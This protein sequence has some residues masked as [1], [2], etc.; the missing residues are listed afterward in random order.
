MGRITKGSFFCLGL[1][2]TSPLLALLIG[3][4]VLSLMSI[5]LVLVFFNLLFSHKE[6]YEQRRGLSQY[7]LGWMIISLLSTIFGFI[8]FYNIDSRYSFAA[9][10]FLPKIVLYLFLYF[11]LETDK[12]G[13]SKSSY[14][15]NG[16]KIGI[17]LNLVWSIVD[18]IMYYTL[19]IS[20]TNTVFASYIQA[21]DMHYGIASIVDGITIRSVGLNNDPATIGFFSIAGAV[22]GSVS[23]KKWMI[24]VCFLAALS[25]VSF[26]GVLGILIA[27]AANFSIS[28]KYQYKERIKSHKYANII[29]I[30]TI[31]VI[32]SAWVINTENGLV[33]QF[34]T[35]IELRAESKIEG[36]HSGM[37]RELFLTKFPHCVAEL[38]TSLF[39]GTGYY[40]GVYAY[41]QEG[42][43]YGYDRPT[44]MEN[45]YVDNFFSFGLIG[46]F[47]FVAFYIKMSLKSFRLLCLH[48]I[49]QFKTIYS[50]G[51]AAL[52]SFFTYH[53]TLYSVIMLVSIAAIVYM[54]KTKEPLRTKDSFMLI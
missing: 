7:F 42:V 14:I 9:L 3:G 1:G 28:K 48:N 24:L 36:D 52:I 47:L 29:V 26:V 49:P 6:K 20:L 37:T 31:L 10:S 35:A 15:L 54:T 4:R 21:T 32:T 46:F 23:K 34:R 38:P 25:C 12:R 19:R 41:Y 50:V 5:S 18:A 11:L 22:Y 30:M 27:L 44:E 45:T 2:A 13:Y 8:Y 53:Y 16:I 51:I 33:S 40:T 17:G 39:I 43:D